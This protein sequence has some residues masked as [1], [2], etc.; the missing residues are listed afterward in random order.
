MLQVRIFNGI[1][2]MNN[3]FQRNYANIFEE[4]LEIDVER[5][6]VENRNEI[7]CTIIILKQQYVEEY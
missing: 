6:L 5:Y 7:A 1:E 3:F 4:I 2:N